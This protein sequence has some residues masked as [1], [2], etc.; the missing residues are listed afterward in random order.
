VPS[1]HFASET[2]LGQS[3]AVFGSSPFIEIRVLG[4]NTTG[5]PALYNKVIDESADDPSI[6]IF[7]HDDV[8]LCDFYWVGQV[9]AGLGE[10]QIIGLAGNKRRVPRQPAWLFIDD[11]FTWDD[12]ANLSG[13]VAHGKGFPDCVLSI[14]GELGQQVMLLDGLFLACHS[15]MLIQNNLRFDEQFD[16]HF[17]D[18]DF[19]RQAENKGLKM[20]TWPISMIHESEGGFGGDAWRRSYMRYLDKWKE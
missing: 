10:F 14:F 4:S 6:L 5:L 19:C 12:F 7:V 15:Q 1:G 3:L 8:Y 2:A 17:Y 9:I 13:M 16:F 20:G 18:M 11:K